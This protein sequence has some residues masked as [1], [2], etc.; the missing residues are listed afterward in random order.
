MQVR[1]KIVLFSRFN[2]S[3]AG[4]P[5]GDQGLGIHPTTWPDNKKGTFDWTCDGTRVETQ[6]WLVPTSFFSHG[7]IRVTQFLLGFSSFFGRYS[8]PS[9]LATPEKF[10]LAV[11]LLTQ[12]TNITSSP[13]PPPPSSPTQTTPNPT[14]AISFTSAANIPFALPPTVALGFGIVAFRQY[15]WGRLLGSA[16]VNERVR[17][18]VQ[19]HLQRNLETELERER[20]RQKGTAAV[21]SEKD[22]DSPPPIEK[23]EGEEGSSSSVE[24][25]RGWVLM[26][27]VDTPGDLL[28]LLVECNYH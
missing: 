20:Q 1:G 28:P 14:L 4:W 27:Y 21:L 26:D 18:W 3:D 15:W 6:D 23:L 11:S 5:N 22:S 12:P 10:Q 16:G 13:P 8:I 19:L 25:V 24:K 17:D 9:F 7:F 2:D